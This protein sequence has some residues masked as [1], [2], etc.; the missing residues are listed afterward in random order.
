MPQGTSKIAIRQNG[1][2]TVSLN[3]SVETTDIGQISLVKFMNPAGLKSIGQNLYEE[4]DASGIPMI[5]VANEEGFGNIN[6]Y[7]LEGSNV[8]VISE[9]MR[10]VMIQ[11]VFDTVSK[12]VQSYDSMLNAINSMKQ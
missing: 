4:T 7:A 11:R 1:T 3:N 12:A 5:G 10:M 2:V 6:Q 9:M 8:D